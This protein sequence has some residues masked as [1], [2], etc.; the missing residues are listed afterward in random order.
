M[1]RRGSKLRKFILRSLLIVVF[2][3]SVLAV[4]TR[5][6]IVQ[7]KVTQYLA[8]EL[9]K[10][11]G[12]KIEIG[13]VEVDFLRNFHLESIC[14]YDKHSDTILFSKTLDFR[15]QEAFISNKKMLISDLD[16]YKLL[17]KMGEYPGEN[18][19]NY[20]FI[21]EY[22]T[23]DTTP[24]SGKSW[25]VFLSNIN[26]IESEFCYFY[27]KSPLKSN[28]KGEFNPDYI[29]FSS[30]NAEISSGEISD[31]KGFE[32]DIKHLEAQERSGFPVNSLQ[33]ILAIKGGIL[34]LKPLDLQ[35]GSTQIKGAFSMDWSKPGSINNHY[36][37]VIYAIGVDQ[38]KIRLSDVGYF[39]PWLKD[40]SID[41][42]A[43]LH[44][45]GPLMHLKS[46]DCRITTPMGSR[47][48]AEVDIFDA[49]HT[50][51][52]INEVLLTESVFKQA[53]I[54]K[55]LEVETFTPS[56]LPFGDALINAFLHIPMTSVDFKGEC[57]TA[58][59]TYDGHFFID[60]KRLDDSLAY[61]AHGLVK[62]FNPGVFSDNFQAFR[63]VDA[64]VKAEGYNFDE[65]A[66]SDFDIKL[67]QALINDRFVN[68]I[69]AVG[70][71]DN[72]NLSASLVA[73]DPV[74]K[75][76]SNIEFDQLF[77]DQPH[78]NL[79]GKVNKV[80][81]KQL[82]F[83]TVNL[84]FGGNYSANLQGWNLDDLTGNVS[85]SDFR[86]LRGK[87]E[88]QLRFQ[89]INRPNNA[90]LEF[91]GDWV[92]GTVKGPWKLTNT[93]QWFQHFAHNVAPE[94]FKEIDRPILDSIEIDLYIPQTSWIEAFI[95]PGLYL[96]PVGIRGN[97]FAPNNVCDLKIGPMSIEYGRI[98]MER[99]MVSIQKPTANGLLKSKFT[100]N[101]VLVE[102][103]VYDTLGF[104]F[105]ITN[106]GYTISS[107]L[108]DK[109]D[110]YGLKLGGN[111][112]ISE[113]TA[114]LD[115]K[116]TVLKIYDQTWKLDDQASIDFNEDHWHLHDF[117]L[118]DDRHYLELKGDVSDNTRDT[119]KIEFSNISQKVLKPFFPEGTFDSLSFKVN[120][121]LKIS[122]VL[123]DFHFL[124]NLDVNRL[125]YLGFD[126]GAL[127]L[128]VEETRT[129][130]Q[131][132]VLANFRNGPLE[133]TNFKGF[134]QLK[135]GS[136]AELD[137]LGVIPMQS[138]LN[139]L[140]PLLTEIV[141]FKSGNIGGNIRITGTTRKPKLVG[142]I[143]VNGARLGVDYL[144]TEYSMSGNFKLTDQGLY[145]MRPIKFYDDT[146]KNFGLMDLALTHE[147]FSDFALDLK[148]DSLKNMKVLQT[149][150]QM[151]DLFYGT[152]YA[153]GNAHIYGLFSEID[154]D[155]AL[156]TRKKTKLAIQYPQVSSN[157]VS[158][159][160]SFVSKTD[161]SKKTAKKSEAEDDA[162]GKI[163]LDVQAT[164]DAE[165]QF[166]IDKK[167]GDIIKGFG[168]GAMR[169]IYDRDEK[170]YLFGR[171]NIESGEYAFSLPGINLLKKIN[172][173]KGGNITWQGDPF[174]AKVDLSGSFEKKISPSTLMI[175]AGSSGS[176][177]PATRFVSTLYMTGNLFGPNIGFDIQAPDLATT[178]GTAAAEVNSVIQR[179]RSDRDETMRQ[180]IALLLFGNFLPPS[181]AA[182][183]AA[184][185]SSFS[186]AGFAGNSVSTLASSV[187]NDLFS[188]YGIP[189]RIQ[190]NLDDVRN[191][192]GSSN[193]QLFVNSEWFLSDRLRLDLNYDPTVAV[194]VNSVAVPINFN[195]EYKTRD[196]NWRLKAFSRSNNLILQNNNTTTTNGVSGNTLGTGILYRR[197]FDTFKRKSRDTTG[198][199]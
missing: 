105:E 50:D 188:K 148:L 158:G 190:V 49:V 137:V 41:I 198:G 96:G 109:L 114:N 15:I 51:Q 77:S 98:Y 194:L 150:E 127:G 56:L 155:I 144:G 23:Q 163:T 178:S 38:S 133:R 34:K 35:S 66:V 140:Q 182:A 112:S 175:S 55:I 104:A 30:L 20:E 151:N 160:I 70:S 97:Y 47:L 142:L 135:E 107:V 19:L 154:M 132:K 159:S 1:K 143:T 117:F 37:E 95:V 108:H 8:R 152:A 180:S 164:N 83:D 9:A 44:I 167:L 24:T 186:S 147:N 60:H 72:G 40:H 85:L 183:S 116:K 185:S 131:L 172:V 170:I 191:A 18:K 73:D 43:K 91:R 84:N 166:V 181:F 17:V 5:N 27:G 11:L 173:N 139:I 189:T 22:F 196:E 161:K 57:Q 187:V 31:S 32:L 123:S 61:K 59:G 88:F 184:P 94:R 165:V 48:N 103:T 53:D 86:L 169:L 71:L 101:Y 46:R 33:G 171:Y 197:E 129:P 67:N 119:L 13:G 42:H 39:I 78:W 174:N 113:K 115:F 25:D 120:G 76:N 68:K 29:R 138:E 130:G 80:D 124:G 58:L 4:L 28:I 10:E 64:E 16:F 149:T 26:L 156:K 65:S 195:L 54:Q 79:S 153:D 110:R 192:S 12:T 157:Y 89:A 176:S 99:A 6:K 134:V 162:L 141:T 36:E 121:N 7:T 199:K 45:K 122:S 3:S 102:N 118:A 14:V 177:Y 136:D 193:T 92:D 179:I 52:M 63:S 2:L 69:Q 81:L 75:L 93:P 100:T 21:E 126:Y 62:Q 146:K 74:F 128:A 111:G 106:G 82:G 145:T 168:D 90:L 125:K 87:D